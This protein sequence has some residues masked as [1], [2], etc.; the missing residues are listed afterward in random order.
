M[1]NCP[2]HHPLF[3]GGDNPNVYNLRETSPLRS[4]SQRRSISTA[5]I[6]ADLK[7]SGGN[8]HRH[9]LDQIGSG[10][11]IAARGGGRS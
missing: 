3:G 9:R 11:R 2:R 4:E 10:N 1:A 8:S 6:G 5:W 7:V